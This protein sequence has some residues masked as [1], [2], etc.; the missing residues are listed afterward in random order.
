MNFV[1]D[2]FPFEKLIEAE[3]ELKR[4]GHLI[5]FANITFQSKHMMNQ[6]YEYLDDRS[7]SR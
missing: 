5:K 3:K 4:K 1:F 7:L 2:R 6:G